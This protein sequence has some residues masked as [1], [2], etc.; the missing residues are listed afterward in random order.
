MKTSLSFIFIFLSFNG[1]TTTPPVQN[2]V[3][4]YV[5]LA[6]KTDIKVIQGKS[7]KWSC[8]FPVL[9]ESLAALGKDQNDALMRL[10]LLCI[11]E[12]CQ[13][14]GKQVAANVKN[15]LDSP[16]N[17]YRDFLE[18]TG[19]TAE[20]IEAAVQSRKNYSQETVKVLTCNNSAMFR[21]AAF[22]SCIAV[23]VECQKK[24]FF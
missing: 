19:R 18:F 14:L 5:Y 11:K 1:M 22:D 12:Q 8:R 17:D 24:S 10:Q 2:T 9:H 13:E 6:L 20:E 4:Q 3:D 7:K 15:L 21:T 16:E 23:P